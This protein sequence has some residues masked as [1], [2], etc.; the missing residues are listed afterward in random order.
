MGII[1][2][3]HSTQGPH[4]EDNRDCCGIGIQDEAALCVLFD[5]SSSGLDSG[6][7][8]RAATR[9]LVDW[10]VG[11]QGVTADKIIERLRDIRRELAASFRKDSASVM[12]ALFDRR[13]AAHLIHAGDCLAGL[14]YGATA[15][16]WRVAPHTL[17]NAVRDIAI[18]EIAVSPLRNRI[19][20]SFRTSGF[21][22]PDVTGF[23]F[24]PDS[25]LILATDGFWALLSAERQIEFLG[26]GAARDTE[27]LDDC[28]ALVLRIDEEMPDQVQGNDTCNLYF[29]NA[30]G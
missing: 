13:G 4:T 14:R 1:I 30:S 21:M 7:F 22:A 20:R 27:H 24:E 23:A 8:A 10:F 28:S 12:I 15:I 17:A 9:R 29:V 25:D 26:R 2:A 5:G 3:L 19:T 18:E 6:S 16:S 11:E